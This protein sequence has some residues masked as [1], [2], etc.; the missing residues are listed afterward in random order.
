M[1]SVKMGDEYGYRMSP[2]KES[3]YLTVG[4]VEAAH[5]SSDGQMINALEKSVQTLCTNLNSLLL[6]HERSGENN[7]FSHERK[8]SCFSCKGQG[9]IKRLCNSLSYSIV[10]SMLTIWTCGE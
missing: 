10:Q 6:Q 5:S 2:L 3:S 4:T 8:R 1:T 9:H 7:S